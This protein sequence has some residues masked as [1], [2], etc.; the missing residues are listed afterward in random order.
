MR[1]LRYGDGYGDGP[2]ASA[3]K[4]PPYEPH[5]PLKLNHLMLWLTCVTSSAPGAPV[6]LTCRRRPADLNASGL[7]L[8]MGLSAGRCAGQARSMP[9]GDFG[10]A[11]I[12]AEAAGAFIGEAAAESSCAPARIRWSSAVLQHRLYRRQLDKSSLGG[13]SRWRSA[14]RPTTRSAVAAYRF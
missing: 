9:T 10:Y 7:D 13:L 5:R 11:E 12:L 1:D 14:T 3:W 8:A 6:A 2:P 4:P